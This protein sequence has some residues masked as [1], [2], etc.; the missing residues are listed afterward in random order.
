MIYIQRSTGK[1]VPFTRH[2]S[3]YMRK[4]GLYYSKWK[5]NRFYIFKRIDSRAN[6][7]PEYETT[8]NGFRVRVKRDRKL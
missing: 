7:N 6:R 3:G 2:N 1:E 8:I 5:L 4:D